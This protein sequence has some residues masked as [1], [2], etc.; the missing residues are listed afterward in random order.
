MSKV[1]IRKKKKKRNNVQQKENQNEKQHLHEV[2]DWWKSDPCIYSS[3]SLFALVGYANWNISTTRLFEL[4][5]A[6]KGI[7]IEK[8]IIKNKTKRKHF[9]RKRK[10]LTCES[11]RA[12]DIAAN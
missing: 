2:T 12:T 5:I 8:K 9:K 1:F 10:K 7:R 3:F 11:A 6:V 4:L